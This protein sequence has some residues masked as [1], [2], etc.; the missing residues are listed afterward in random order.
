[1][2][3]ST[4]LQARDSVLAAYA[5]ALAQGYRFFSFGDAMLIS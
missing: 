2:S 4:A 1:M 3:R 5:V